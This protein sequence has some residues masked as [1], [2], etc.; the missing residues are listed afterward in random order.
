MTVWNVE[1]M[2]TEKERESHVVEKSGRVVLKG[3]HEL[4]RNIRLN[5]VLQCLILY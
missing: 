2:F 1:E 3:S 5:L 4:G